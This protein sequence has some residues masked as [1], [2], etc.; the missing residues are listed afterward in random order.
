LGAILGPVAAERDLGEPAEVSPDLQAKLAQVYTEPGDIP[1]L[2]LVVDGKAY[3]LPLKHTHVKAEVA[4]GIAR[5]QV[6]Q[7]YQNP[8]TYP[9]ETTYVFPL[10]ENSAVDDMKMV[11]GERIIQAEIQERAQAKATYEAAKA[12]GKTA[13]LLEQERPNLFT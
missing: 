5:V 11:I 2:Q 6:T 9:I 3:E 7:T 8:F 13:A 4:G 10:P 1:R 12:E